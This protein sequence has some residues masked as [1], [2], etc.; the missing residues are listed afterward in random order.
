VL[1][2][3]SAALSED[4]LLLCDNKAVLC[5]VK[6]WVGQG[7]KSTLATSTDPD[8]LQE[9]VCLLTQ[10]VRAGRATFLIKVESHRGEPINDRADTLAEKGREISNDNKRW[11]DRTD[12]MMIEVRKGDTTVC[13]VWTNSV[14]NAFRKQAGRAKLQE[15]RA[16]VARHWTEHVWYRHNQHWE[17]TNAPAYYGHVSAGAWSLAHGFQQASR[18]RPSWEA[19]GVLYGKRSFSVTT[20]ARGQLG[21]IPTTDSRVFVPGL[22]GLPTLEVEWKSETM[23]NR[24]PKL[25]KLFPQNCVKLTSAESCVERLVGCWA[26]SGR[27]GWAVPGRR[28]TPGPMAGRWRS[29]GRAMGLSA[30]MCDYCRFQGR[31]AEMCR[32]LGLVVAD[33]SGDALSHT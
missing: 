6:K 13:S 1:A 2:L 15:V 23:R 26:A 5:V 17:C 14:R 18:K 20:L 19:G 4:A 11:D 27:R 30:G 31:S 21:S 28:A 10:R 8:I 22:P 12:W 24:V 29:A 16:A 7:G 3:Q 32:S 25:P 9:I 33:T